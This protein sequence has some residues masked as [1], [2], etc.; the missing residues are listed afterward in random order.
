MCHGCHCTGLWGCTV[1]STSVAPR[2]G[3]FPSHGTSPSTRA[4]AP[5][6][7][8]PTTWHVSRSVEKPFCSPG[9]SSAVIIQSEMCTTVFMSSQNKSKSAS[10]SSCLAHG[11]SNKLT[12][13]NPRA[14]NILLAPLVIYKELRKILL[15]LGSLDAE[16][17]DKTHQCLSTTA[18][19]GW[20]GESRYFCIVVM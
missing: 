5:A 8:P 17:G 18:G 20:G 6:T 14:A 11:S 15:V 16:T 10:F 2:S 9:L 13:T 19:R 3:P 1:A 12:S 7:Y 4:D